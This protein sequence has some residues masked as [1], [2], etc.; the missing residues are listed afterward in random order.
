[1]LV[2]SDKIVAVGK[3]AFKGVT[4]KVTVKSST[5]KWSDYAK[6]FI[7]KGKMSGS[8]LF[9]IDPVMLKYNGKNY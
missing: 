5:K 1:M 6:L 9:I 7:L 4:S 2:K 8:A 3:N